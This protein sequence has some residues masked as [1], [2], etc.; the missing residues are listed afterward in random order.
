MS[1]IAIIRNVIFFGMAFYHYYQ[2]NK[3][4]N[5]N[6]MSTANY[7]AIH[8]VVYILLATAWD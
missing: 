5:K 1:T 8:V 2:A 3:H 7:H 6:E 4:K